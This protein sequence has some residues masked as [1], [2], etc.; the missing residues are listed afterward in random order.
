MYDI[1]KYRDAGSEQ[2]R[3]GLGETTGVA[4]EAHWKRGDESSRGCGDESSRE[5][6][7]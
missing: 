6:A 7:W 2:G 4:I 1:M 5:D 3:D